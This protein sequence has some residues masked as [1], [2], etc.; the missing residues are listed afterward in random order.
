MRRLRRQRRT[1]VACRRALCNP[2][3]TRWNCQ[4]WRPKRHPTRPP[5]R[6]RRGSRP[7]QQVRRRG[8]WGPTRCPNRVAVSP[9]LATCMSMLRGRK[10]ALRPS[11]PAVLRGRAR[12]MLMAAARP[13][14][15]LRTSAPTP[16]GHCHGSPRGL[17]EPRGRRCGPAHVGP[18]L[19]MPPPAAPRPTVTCGFESS[20][21]VSRF[22]GY[23]SRNS[24]RC[25]AR[26]CARRTSRTA[27]MSL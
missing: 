12:R 11:R 14:A 4:R 16:L 7:P 9:R 13:W 20:T 18:S 21:A 22:L 26:R 6:L 25:W 17:Q 3:R 10:G 1:R 8:Q 27:R 5:A 2:P 19:P 24:V 23:R 15:R